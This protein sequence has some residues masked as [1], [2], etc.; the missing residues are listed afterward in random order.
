MHGTVT[1]EIP[2][3]FSA[4]SSLSL[5]ETALTNIQDLW[6]TCGGNSSTTRDAADDDVRVRNFV[7][8]FFFSLCC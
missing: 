3:D 8:F 5:P 6:V 7:L 4:A 2:L 1:G